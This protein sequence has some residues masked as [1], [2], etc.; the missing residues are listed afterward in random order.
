MRH[1]N[2]PNCGAV[3]TGNRCEYCGTLF[4]DLTEIDP[5]KPFRCNI[6]DI[7]DIEVYLGHVNVEYASNT[8]SYRDENGIMHS[9]VKTHRVITLKLIEA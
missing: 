3:I 4:Y 2:C 1:T 5:L 7:T 9:D 6:K 8:E